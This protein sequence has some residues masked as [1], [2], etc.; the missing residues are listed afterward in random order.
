MPTCR[1]PG[2]HWQFHIQPRMVEVRVCLPEQLTLNL[3][4]LEAISLENELHRVIEGTLR[5][6]LPKIPEPYTLIWKGKGPMP[7][8]AVG[9]LVKANETSLVK[10]LTSEDLAWLYDDWTF[11]DEWDVFNLEGEAQ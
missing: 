5:P 9:D 1:T 11:R 7:H 3:T 8:V 2:A 4:E 6:Y 10:M